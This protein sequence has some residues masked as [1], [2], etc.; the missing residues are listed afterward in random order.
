MMK[1]II[2]MLLF[3]FTGMFTFAISYT[4]NTYQRLADEYTKQAQ[5]AFDAGQYDKAVE[6]SQKALE[7][8]DL[9]KAYI[10]KMVARQEAEQQLKTAQEKIG[11]AKSINAD[12]NFPIA[13][14]AAEDAY[15]NAE[16]AYT[17]EDYESVVTYAKA[18]LD[19]LDGVHEVTPLPEFYIVRPWAD[20]K[21]CYW[22][23]S[24]RPYIYNNP[25]LWENLYQANKTK[26]S[27]PDDPD[28]IL[29]GMKMK[30]PSLTGEYREG[31][32]SPSKN[33]DAYNT[34]R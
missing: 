8:A 6:L 3:A 25:L 15:K 26:M 30:I 22:N 29:P 21:D 19:D 23:I 28:L 11:W 18:V 17:G 14:S 32:Y 7:N 20:T 27:H 16:N 1:K 4:N 12:R 10:Q 2:T 34:N 33:Y 9:S 24:G 5:G 13:Y 31:V